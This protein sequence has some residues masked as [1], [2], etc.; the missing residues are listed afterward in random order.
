MQDVDKVAS[1]IEG[2]DQ[3]LFGGF[4]KGRSYLVAGEPGAGKT[5]FTLQFLLEGLKK[6]EKVIYISIDE[7]PEH[8]IADAEALGWPLKQSLESGLFQILDVTSHFASAQLGSGGINIDQI[9]T[10]VLGFVRNFG[11]TRLVIDPISPLIFSE[12]HIPEVAEYIRRLI[13]AIE[14]N[15]ECTTL[16]TSYSPVGSD[17]VSHHGIE[18]FA[19]SGIIILK[20]DKL[21]TK[22]IRTVRVKKMRGTRVD[23]SEYSFEILPQRGIVLRQPI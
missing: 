14:D 3:V 22:Y 8:V 12:R 16:L 20:L 18:E 19:A 4:P 13:F 21:N 2:F 1:G 23:L 5:I 15:A 10:E 7:K 9:I 6:G 11:A 17:K